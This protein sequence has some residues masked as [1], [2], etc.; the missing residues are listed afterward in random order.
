MRARTKKLERQEKEI[1]NE[2]EKAIK[3][4]D[5]Q[6]IAYKK[7]KDSKGEKDAINKKRS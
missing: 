5:S 4:M 7:I 1:R 2:M 3:V 6:I